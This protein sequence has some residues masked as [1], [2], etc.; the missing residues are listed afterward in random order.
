ML[1]KTGMAHGLRKLMQNFLT[2]EYA[3]NAELKFVISA[4]FRIEA[5]NCDSE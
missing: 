2:A 5:E 4:R 3:E 1:F